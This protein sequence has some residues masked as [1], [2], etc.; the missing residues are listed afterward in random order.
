MQINDPITA[1]RKLK[2]IRLQRQLTQLQAA[3]AAGVSLK[4]YT[5]FEK[6]C[7]PIITDTLTSICS[8]LGCTPDD[9]LIDKKED[10]AFTD[11]CSEPRLRS[12][13][14]KR[15]DREQ[16]MIRSFLGTYLAKTAEYQRREQSSD[17]KD[18]S[19]T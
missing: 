17:S 11:N 14:H 9:I 12:E 5:N 7:H 18:K 8:A 16:E 2:E 15:S 4:T 6:G 3:E 1:G 10:Q 13:L 19:S